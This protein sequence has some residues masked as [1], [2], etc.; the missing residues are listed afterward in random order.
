MQSIN[1]FWFRRDL[2]LNDNVGL[3]H[4]LD[5]DLPVL[6]L[7]IF[8]TDIIDDLQDT[9]DPRVEFIHQRLKIL[10][11]AL[12]SHGSSILV[13]HG[14][15]E[16]VIKELMDE[17]NLKAVYTNHDYEPYARI[18]DQKIEKLL[19]ANKVLF[20]T[21]KDQVIFEKDE[22]MNDQGEPYK[23][24]TPYSRRWLSLLARKDLYDGIPV[25]N[26]S[27]F[28]QTSPLEMPSLPD[29]G[30]QPTGC[31][32]PDN[33]LNQKLIKKYD[34]DRNFPF[35]RGTSRLGVHLR[36]GTISIRDAVKTARA[37]NQTWLN[38]L[39]WREFYMMVLYHHPFVVDHAFKPQYEKIPWRN[40]PEDFKKWCQGQTG[41]PIVDAGM[42]ELNK[43]YFMHNRV[44]M[45][46]AS[47]LTKH[48]LIDWRWGEAYFAQKLL[49]YELASNNGGWQWAAGTG[50]DAQPY[51]RIFN[52]YSQQQK[53]DP[54]YKYIRKWVPEFETDQYPEPIVEHKSARERAINT[55]KTALNQ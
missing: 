37:L 52:P 40:A 51:F 42:R 17:Y 28:Y 3:Y 6:P 4:A 11:Q 43:S 8:D 32:F 22:I 5:A 44:R 30:F 29:I 19:R 39:I 7:F 47:F 50:T 41:Y 10:D 53:F 49:D 15:P 35:V 48:L 13:K 14:K 18:R 12:S 54:E 25:F 33:G 9:K 34:S 46:T 45:I 38:E 1:I 20:F 36:H 55:F 27:H 24:F 26:P 16:T 31:V 2:R 23:V 21:F